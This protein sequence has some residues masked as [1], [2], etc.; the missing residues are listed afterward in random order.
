MNIALRYIGR[1]ITEN[2]SFPVR[3][4]AVLVGMRREE[5]RVSGVF[6]F[7]IYKNLKRNFTQKEKCSLVAVPLVSGM[8][9]VCM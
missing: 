7:K 9:F 8:S 5:N 3:S 6:E 1:R 4:N 2:F